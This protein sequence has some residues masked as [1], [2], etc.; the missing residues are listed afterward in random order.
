MQ[1]GI[2]TQFPCIKDSVIMRFKSPFKIITERLLILFAVAVVTLAAVTTAVAGVVWVGEKAPELSFEKYLNA[3]PNMPMSLAGFKGKVVVI[4]FF[5]ITCPRCQAAMP[6]YSNLATAMKGKPVVFLSLSN[7]DEG[8][9]RNFMQQYSVSS[10]VALDPDWS[11][12]RDYAVLG[13]P[14]AVVINPQGVIAALVHPNDL[15]EE[16][17]NEALAGATPSVKQTELLDDPSAPT[18]QANKA[19]PLMQVEVRPATPGAK[20]AIW[21]KTEF[22]ARAVTL[23]DLL[24]L[25]LNIDSYL[26]VSDDLLLDARYDV[27]I[28]PPTPS[29]DMV[30]AML[31]SVVEQM[32]HPRLRQVTRP[33]KVY[34]LRSRPA[35]AMRLTPGGEATPSINST[36]GKVHATNVPISQIISN[37][38]KQLFATVI[39]E[40]GLTGGYNFDLTWDVN[41]PKSV[42]DS[43]RKQL[44]LD[45][46][47]ETRPMEVYLVKRG[48]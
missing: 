24:G 26:F 32:A 23:A 10:F 2:P 8:A 19:L 27:T 6:H 45:V 14:F 47:A 46:R 15:S 33:T 48:E 4:E 18:T 30:D 35:S 44:G 29:E 38:E 28:T 31:R 37:L 12:W 16:V 1:I 3:P 41:N 34:V 42:L 17:I 25:V 22:R 13:I 39:D 20:P 36:S 43:L 7:E 9:V 11:M 21:K 40:T 5:S